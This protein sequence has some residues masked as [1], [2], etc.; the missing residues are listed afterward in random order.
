MKK[1]IILICALSLLGA[2]GCS[3]ETRDSM[4]EA[5]H[6]MARDVKAAG[7]DMRDAAQDATD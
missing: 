7:R 5:G 4:D 2:Y 6:D 3:R 1:G